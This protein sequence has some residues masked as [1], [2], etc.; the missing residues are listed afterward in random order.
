MAFLLVGGSGSVVLGIGGG[1]EYD[2]IRTTV[3]MCLD[4]EATGDVDKLRAAFHPDARMFGSLARQRYDVP[5]TEPFDLA[6]SAP[7]DTGRYR[8]RILSIQQTGDAAIERDGRGGGLLGNGGVR[9]QPVAREDRREVDDRQQA[10]RPHP[11]RTPEL[12]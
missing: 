5:I 11:G 6:A 12:D 9:R 1:D 7:A 10:V 2:A 8:S 4:G 3:Q